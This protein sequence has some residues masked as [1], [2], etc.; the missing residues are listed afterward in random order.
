[1]KTSVYEQIFVDTYRHVACLRILRIGIVVW[2]CYCRPQWVFFSNS[3]CALLP[4]KFCDS[5][6]SDERDSY[7]WVSQTTESKRPGTIISGVSCRRLGSSQQRIPHST[8]AYIPNLIS[9]QDCA[10]GEYVGIFTRVTLREFH[11]QIFLR[12]FKSKQ[13]SSLAEST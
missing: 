13:L 8:R 5:L 11:D 9:V 1:M 3:N 6:D 10:E 12:E 7:N 4:S 2:S